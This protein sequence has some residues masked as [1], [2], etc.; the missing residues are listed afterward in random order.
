MMWTLAPASTTTPPGSITHTTVI[1][2]PLNVATYLSMV[3]GVHAAPQS[4]SACLHNAQSCWT[5]YHRHTDIHWLTWL[6]RMHCVYMDWGYMDSW[7]RIPVLFWSCLDWVPAVGTASY[8]SQEAYLK[9]KVVLSNQSKL[10]QNPDILVGLNFITLFEL[11]S[12]RHLPNKTISHKA[13]NSVW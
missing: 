11:Q 4:H 9:V 6:Y 8:L 7:T 13:I 12:E 1:Q 2:H 3:S 10:V 5:G